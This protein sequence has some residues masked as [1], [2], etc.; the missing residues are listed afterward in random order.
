MSKTIRLTMAQAL[1]RFLSRQMTEIDGRTVPIFGGVWAIFGHGNVAGIGE[2]LYQVRDELPTFRAHNEQAMAHAAIAYGKANFRRRFMAATSSIGPGALNMVTAAALAHVNRLPVL[3]LPGDVF[4]NRIPD[5]VL[6]QAEDFSDGTATVNDCFRPVSRYFDRITRP[7]QIIP[8]LSRAMQVLT[9]PADCGPVTLSLCQ[10]VQAEAYDYPESFFAERVWRQ[11]RPRPDRS[12]L[13]AA[14]AALK[15]ARKPLIIAG[16][17]VLYS[18]ASDELATFAEGAGIPVCET[19]GGKSSLPDD[20]KL[21]M[22]AV[23]VTGTSAANRLAEEADV[24]LAIGTR[25]QD[26]TTGS[27]A[28]FKNSGKTIIGLNVQPFD[29]GKHRALPLVADA[30][31]GL[32]ELGAALQGWKA[33]VAWT[34]NAVTGKTTWQADAAKVTAS[35]NV[36]FPSDAQVIGAVQR[37]MGSGVTLLHAAGGLP[38]E[39][40][41][42]WQAGAPGSYHAEYG[43]STMGY[44]IAGGLGTKMAKPGEEIV[45]MIGDGSYLMLNSEIATSVMLGLKLTIVLLDNRGFGCINRLQMATGGANFNNLLKD[46]RHE[47]L[48]DVDFA[49]HAASMGATSEKVSS[50]AGLETALAQAK[51]ND[52]TTVLVID[53]DPLVSTD[54]GGHWWDVAVPEVSARPQVNAARKAYDE[55]RRM[56]SV[57]D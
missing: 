35:T 31:E 21:N 8:A 6:Q 49:A 26:F 53:T 25:L 9:D 54:A 17:G 18:Q 56:Q 22:A 40:H 11:R 36:A 42:L 47:I 19:Q 4:A 38:G 33:P 29:A 44:E 27:W 51:K 15:G 14:V 1:T 28:L 13:A 12:E 32:A 50:I 45:V 57:G 48:P 30:A 2:A 16:G 23:G 46:S 24:V 43:F 55:K 39:L 7:E 3:F 34:D 41:K 37:A 10:D 20:H 5:P 52:R